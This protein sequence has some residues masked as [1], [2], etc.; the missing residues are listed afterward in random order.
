MIF[1]GNVARFVK[2]SSSDKITMKH[3][4]LNNNNINREILMDMSRSSTKK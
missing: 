1:I 3:V 2:H 4:G